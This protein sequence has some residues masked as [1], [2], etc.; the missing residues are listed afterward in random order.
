MANLP[1]TP[2]YGPV[3][4]ERLDELDNSI[5]EL[6]KILKKL[7]EGIKNEEKSVERDSTN[8]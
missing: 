4:L 5:N 1:M 7:L 2:N 8:K 6:N 3:I